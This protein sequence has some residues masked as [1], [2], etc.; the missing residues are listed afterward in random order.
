MMRGVARGVDAPTS[1]RRGT[2]PRIWSFARPFRG[3]LVGFLLLTVVSATVGV[4][5]PVLAGQVVNTIVAGGAGAP[6]R[7]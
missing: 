2:I 1:V 4:A 3:W 5:T 6:P 7:W